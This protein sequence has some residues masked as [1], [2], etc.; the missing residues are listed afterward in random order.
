MLYNLVMWLQ[1]VTPAPATGTS[2][3]SLIGVATLLIPVIYIVLQIIKQ[4]WTSLSGVT[5]I[6]VNFALTAIAY[7]IALPQDQWF[8][9]S[10]LLALATTVAG[11]AGIHGTVKGLL[12]GSEPTPSTPAEKL[13]K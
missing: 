8:T 3:I 12:K 4:A 2:S 1:T 6:V 11:A 5:A 7:V 13:V 9:M 10:T